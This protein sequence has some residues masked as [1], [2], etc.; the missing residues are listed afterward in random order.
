MRWG[1][2]FTF[3][4]LLLFLGKCKRVVGGYSCAALID[5]RKKWRYDV[6]C[7]R[8]CCGAIYM[9]TDWVTRGGPREAVPQEALY[10]KMKL[11]SLGKNC[12]HPDVEL[13]SDD[14]EEVA[15]LTVHVWSSQTLTKFFKGLRKW[16]A[17]WNGYQN[18]EQWSQKTPHSPCY[19][20][21]KCVW[22]LTLL[23]LLLRAVNLFPP[24]WIHCTSVK[25]FKIRV[26]KWN[27]NIP[28]CNLQNVW[29]RQRHPANF[30]ILIHFPTANSTMHAWCIL[31]L[32]SFAIANRSILHF[33]K[34]KNKINK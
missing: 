28:S 24:N 7:G 20:R 18:L 21:N 8:F 11:L 10:G 23:L 5:K 17:G 12:P 13:M 14:C 9:K 19:N 30:P 31:F 27:P 34:I 32:K 15:N 4:S 3:F 16:K 1:C 29:Y 26:G 33:W 25:V 6:V 2:T 22:S